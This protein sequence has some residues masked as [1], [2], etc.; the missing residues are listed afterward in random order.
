[1]RAGGETVARSQLLGRDQYTFQISGW[2][3]RAYTILA[4]TE[5]RC[6]GIPIRTSPYLTAFTYL[7][8]NGMHDT[9][10]SRPRPSEQ[11]RF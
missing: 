6:D 7:V 11:S 2:S 3:K 1:L 8:E 4:S 9:N 10:E 5:V